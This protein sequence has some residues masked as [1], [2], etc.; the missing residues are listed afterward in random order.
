MKSRWPVIAAG[1]IGYVAVMALVLGV[2][3]LALALSQ[4]DGFTAARVVA[5]LF[6]LRE[7]DPDTRTTWEITGFAAALLCISQFA[8]LVPVVPRRLPQRG[9]ARSLVA[10]MAAAG[11]VAAVL[12]CGL[13]VAVFG[14]M[15]LLLAHASPKLDPLDVHLAGEKY[16]GWALL[17]L[18]FASWVLW[19]TLLVRFARRVPGQGAL[20]TAAGWLLAG[21]IAEVLVVLPLD[22]MVRRRTGCYCAAPSF[23]AL[24]IS[25]W[26]LLWLAGPGIV[27]ALLSR[28]RRWW[29]DT[30]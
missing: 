9:R 17:A 14:L 22:I 23:W 3:W 27:I 28:R 5:G 7:S 15:Q 24:C 10:S 13:A 26:A 8:F 30:P 2:I 18:L 6:P 25:T 12:T 4:E 20:A 1:V 11:F 19:S 29:T 16:L 21:T